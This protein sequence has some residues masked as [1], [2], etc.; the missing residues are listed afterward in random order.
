MIVKIPIRILAV[1]TAMAATL[2]V[3]AALAGAA[4][5]APRIEPPHPGR[6]A[7]GAT[8]LNWAGYSATGSSFTS[9]TATW[10]QPA[11]KAR[12]AETY[13]AFWVG[14]DGDGSDTVEQIGT[15]GYTFGGRCLLRRLVRDVSGGH[16]ADHHDG[17]CR[18][19]SDRAPCSGSGRRRTRSRSATRRAEGRSRRRR[20]ARP[21]S[22]PRPRSSPRRP[23]PARPAPCCRSR[24]SV[25]P[26]HR[27]RRRR[28]HPGRRRRFV[29]RHGRLRRRHHR[30]DLGARRRTTRASPSPTTSR[31]PR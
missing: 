20:R 6:A 11:V 27:L 10:T 23:R 13:A 31:R 28:R 3:F 24:P 15:M 7:S 30:L 25:S 18:A 19:T 26:L 2:V 22:A 29:H 12:T 5:A 4:F 21:P 14:L 9:V 8:S 16:E 1:L 17:A